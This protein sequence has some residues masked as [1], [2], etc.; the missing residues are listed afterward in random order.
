MISFLL[1]LKRFLV[2]FFRIVKE[3]F[4]KSVLIT[5]VAILLS[6]TMF[7]KGVEGWSLLNSFYFSFISLIPTGVSTGLTPTTILGKWFTMIYLVI[8]TGVM[9]LVLIRIGLAV[10]SFE[11]AEIDEMN[12]RESNND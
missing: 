12:M 11:R 4:S 8:G 3:P 5:L 10:V 6:G 1:S 2:A 7:Y 9:L